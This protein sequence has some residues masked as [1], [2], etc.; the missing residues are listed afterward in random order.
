MIKEFIFCDSFLICQKYFLKISFY[1][2]FLT[3]ICMSVYGHRCMSARTQEYQKGAS[4][5][6]EQE[7]QVAELE[8]EL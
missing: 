8:T 5:A 7:L 1:P 4:S 3:F 2:F 6:L